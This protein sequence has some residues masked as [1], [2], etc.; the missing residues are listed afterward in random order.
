MIKLRALE[1]GFNYILYIYIQ[2]I[3]MLQDNKK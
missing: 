3:I 1:K 2:L